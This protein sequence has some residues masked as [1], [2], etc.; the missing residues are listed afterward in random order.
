M[1]VMNET[2]ND[3]QLKII[4]NRAIVLEALW[5]QDSQINK[6][7]V[8]LATMEMIQKIAYAY[9]DLENDFDYIKQLN[10]Y[11]ANKYETVFRLIPYASEID[12]IINNSK[13]LYSDEKKIE[14]RKLSLARLATICKAVHN[15]E[16]VTKAPTFED[17]MKGT[18]DEKRTGKEF[19]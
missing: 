3:T 2:S 12:Y 6:K 15:T 19:M 16:I 4:K 13:E 17:A 5:L 8:S 11:L 1:D 9:A 7:D 18:E 10:T 14:E